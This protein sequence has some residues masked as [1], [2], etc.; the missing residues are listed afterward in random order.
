[1]LEKMKKP[2][3][4][5]FLSIALILSAIC[6]TFLYTQK[7]KKE[8]I[9]EIYSEEELEGAKIKEEENAAK[10]KIIVHID[11]EV[12]N[13]GVYELEKDARI[14][15]AIESAGGFT[16]SADLT[17]INL[18]YKISDGVKISIPKREDVKSVKK[19]AVTAKA[20]KI[21]SNSTT[22]ITKSQE[23]NSVDSGESTA[24]GRVNLNTATIS[25]LDT[26][27]GIGPTIAQ[28]IIDYREQ[29]GGFNSIDDL[30]LVNGIGE[31]K[32]NK[33]KDSIEI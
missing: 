8:I 10:E 33:I 28:M 19:T 27:N 1:M 30:K 15:D 7:Q 6:A 4:I 17:E 26:L 14:D 22:G 13:P 11:G 31:A 3:I 23:M 2:R 24:D 20:K 5:S 18:A 29:N 9:S 12:N 21:V 25:Q 32:F 16:S